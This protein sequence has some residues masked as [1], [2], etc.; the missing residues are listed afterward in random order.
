M[1]H[2]FTSLLLA[3]YL[4][5]FVVL[6][7]TECW[8]PSYTRDS[9]ELSDNC[10]SGYTKSGLLCYPPC[11]SGY[12]NVAGVCWEKCEDGYMDQGALC[13]RNGKKVKLNNLLN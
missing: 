3:I 12:N 11:K 2:F 5:S 6:S 7:S 8:R 1:F 9:T 10:P 4:K 13:A